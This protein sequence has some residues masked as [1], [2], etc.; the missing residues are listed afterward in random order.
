MGPTTKILSLCTLYGSINNSSV[1]SLRFLGNSLVDINLKSSGKIK[2][3]PTFKFP[4]FRLKQ[5]VLNLTYK[6]F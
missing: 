6:E 4:H 1:L 2:I 3:A 5:A